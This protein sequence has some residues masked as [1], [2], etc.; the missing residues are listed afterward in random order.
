MNQSGEGWFRVIRILCVLLACRCAA[1]DSPGAD[2][3]VRCKYCGAEARDAR[4]LLSASCPKHPAGFAKGRHALFEGE[5]REEYACVYCGQTAKSIRALVSASCPKHPDGFA[6]GRH[7]AY[8]GAPKTSY[9][10]KY[11]GQSANSLR[12]LV[13]ASCPRHPNGFAKGKHSPSR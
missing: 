13:S 8:E 3:G 1:I 10:C 7:C 11:C 12:A 4:A 6:K 5:L 2:M 9:V